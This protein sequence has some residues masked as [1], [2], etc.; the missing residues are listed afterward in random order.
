[1][2]WASW[3]PWMDRIRADLGYDE[4]EDEAAAR[5]LD[6]LLE[7]LSDAPVV[8]YAWR[9]LSRARVVVAGAADDA[10]DG[11]RRSRKRHVLVTAD[12]ATSAAREAGRVPDVVVT[13]LDGRV[14]DQL[15]AARQGALVFVHAHGDNVDRLD[16]WVPQFPGSNVAGT[17]Q[18][19]ASGRLVNPGGF[20]DGDRA[21]F[22][23]HAMGAR[24]VRLVGF[25]LEGPIGRWTGDHDPE[26]KRRKLAWCGRLLG[27]LQSE[28]GFRLDPA[29]APPDSAST[30]SA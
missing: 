6:A 18:V 9:L 23:A 12:G 30:Q 26:T 22:L 29:F 1:M 11:I 8:D 4:A 2:D 24:Q 16:E 3:A 10:A 7:T 21:C 20:T 25:D 27:V 14:E 28:T 5:R 17:C 19:R 15:W 13:D